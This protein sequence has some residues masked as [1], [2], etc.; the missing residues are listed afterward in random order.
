MVT[1]SSD[2]LVTMPVNS[3]NR[4]DAVEFRRLQ[5]LVKAMIR[6]GILLLPRIPETLACLFPGHRSGFKL[7]LSESPALS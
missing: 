5:Y 1:V 2:A 7:R 3:L 6:Q 4:F